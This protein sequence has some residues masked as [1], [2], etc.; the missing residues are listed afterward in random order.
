MNLNIL[1]LDTS[2][3]EHFIF[4]DAYK[5]MQDG[6]ALNKLPELFWKIAS[7]SPEKLCTSLP[8]PDSPCCWDC[9]NCKLQEHNINACI[10]KLKPHPSFFCQVFV[11]TTEYLRDCVAFVRDETKLMP[12]LNNSWNNFWRLVCC[13]VLRVLSVQEVLLVIECFSFVELNGW[14]YAVVV[15]VVVV[16]VIQVSTLQPVSSHCCQPWQWCF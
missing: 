14:C 11:G 3:W 10:S 13:W 7:G 9:E 4:C 1:F 2:Q 16:V 15:V 5:A 8:I 6:S 12:S